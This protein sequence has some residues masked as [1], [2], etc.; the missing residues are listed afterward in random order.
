MH[1]PHNAID[2]KRKEI[3]LKSIYSDVLLISIIGLLV[4][5]E[6]ASEE[7]KME[8]KLIGKWTE[9]GQDKS[10]GI[11]LFS[12]YSVSADA[13]DMKLSGKWVILEDSRI[14]CTLSLLGIEVIM[15]GSLSQD[16]LM[17]GIDG[18]VGKFLKVDEKN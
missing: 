16:T 12:D 14:K 2:S 13:G 9:I 18:D 8:K 11:E 1:E 10:S 3:K 15:M 17:L 6:C 4:F 5:A 7:A